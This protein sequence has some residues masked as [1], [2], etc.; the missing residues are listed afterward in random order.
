MALEAVRFQMADS[1]WKKWLATQGPDFKRS[2]HEGGT[3][4]AVKVAWEAGYDEGRVQGHRAEEEGQ[5]AA[6][7]RAAPS[8]SGYDKGKQDG[9]GVATGRIKV[10]S[11]S[12]PRYD[13]G[14][15]DGYKDAGD[16]GDWE[17]YSDK[18]L[19]RTCPADICRGRILYLLAYSTSV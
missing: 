14:V 10:G 16:S 5:R 18:N 12:G 8:D 1:L 7:P 4:Y 3:L 19:V 2:H 13:E 17:L 6:L 15:R 9:Y 11:G